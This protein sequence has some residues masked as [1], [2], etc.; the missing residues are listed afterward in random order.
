MSVDPSINNNN[1]LIAPIYDKIPLSHLLEAA[2]QK[3][4]HELYTM[5]D[6]YV[7]P[8]HIFFIN[9]F[10]FYLVYMVKPFYNGRNSSFEKHLYILFY[11]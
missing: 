10:D 2:V 9:L 5:A 1:A 11:H 4:Y 8:L 7:L 3:T 6:V